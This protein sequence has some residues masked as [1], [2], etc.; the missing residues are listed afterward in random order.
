MLW[1]GQYSSLIHWVKKYF[2]SNCFNLSL[3]V[4]LTNLSF[5]FQ[6]ELLIVCRPI[7]NFYPCKLNLFNCFFLF[8]FEQERRSLGIT[9]ENA[10]KFCCQQKKCFSSIFQLQLLYP[11]TEQRMKKKVSSKE[12]NSEQKRIWSERRKI[13]TLGNT[14]RATFIMGKCKLVIIWLNFSH[15]RLYLRGKTLKINKVF[16]PPVIK[17]LSM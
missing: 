13:S 6:N 17:S 2:S 5:L 15:C 12:K 16:F 10:S 9:V 4:N 11:F 8:H 3:V 1:L 7:P 14:K